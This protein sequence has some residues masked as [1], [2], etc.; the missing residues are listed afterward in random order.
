MTQ[1][2]VTFPTAGLVSLLAF[3]EGQAGEGAQIVFHPEMDREQ[4]TGALELCS[5]VLCPALHMSLRARGVPCS[6]LSCPPKPRLNRGRWGSGVCYI[7]VCTVPHDK[8]LIKHRQ[9]GST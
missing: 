5:P 3:N 7:C 2:P 9:E 1:L 6:S 8:R 4:L